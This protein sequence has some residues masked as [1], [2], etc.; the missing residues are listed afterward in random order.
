MQKITEIKELKLKA[1]KIRK[2]IISMLLE[3]KSGHS[4][5]PLGMADIF[6]ALYFNEMN[7]KPQEP[8]WNERDRLVL[9]NAH[10]CPVRYGTFDW[11][12]LG[13][14]SS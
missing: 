4:A 5:G 9:S 1:N 3:A 11:K 12:R 13:E 2:D 14:V 6:A 8:Y 7:H 10:I